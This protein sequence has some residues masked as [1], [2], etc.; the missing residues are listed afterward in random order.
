MDAK[1]SVYPAQAQHD[2]KL[3]ELGRGLDPITRTGGYPD[4]ALYG[5]RTSF[6]REG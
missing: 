6:N 2:G 4:A 5:L 1:R 3:R